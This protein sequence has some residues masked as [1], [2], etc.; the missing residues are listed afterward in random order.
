M[1]P[2]I[3]FYFVHINHEYTA[4]MVIPGG[5]R[6]AVT[7]RDPL[8]LTS[9]FRSVELTNSVDAATQYGTSR[10]TALLAAFQHYEV[11]ICATCSE[12]RQYYS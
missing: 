6:L 7:P 11:I 10:R 8:N 5:Q 3:D 2:C 9:F 1:P 12:I 4:A